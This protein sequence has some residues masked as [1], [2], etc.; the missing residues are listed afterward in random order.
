MKKK[1]MYGIITIICIIIVI[2]AITLKNENNIEVKQIKSEKQ[3]MNVYDNNQ[4]DIPDFL[5]RIFMA[6]GKEI[7]SI[8]M[9]NFVT[10]PPA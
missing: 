7:F 2:I 3:L 6:S 1:V 5:A 9:I 8:S 4:E 10:F